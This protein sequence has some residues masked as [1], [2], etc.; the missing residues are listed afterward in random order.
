MTSVPLSAVRSVIFTV[1]PAEAGR[2][3]TGVAVDTVGAVGSVFAWVALALVD[4]L[5]A[6][7]APKARHAGAQ[8][9]VHFVLAEASVTTGVCGR[10]SE[11]LRICFSRAS[12]SYINPAEDTKGGTSENIL[13]LQSSM[14][15]SQLRPVKPG[16]QPQW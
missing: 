12:G 16:L 4:V 14:L 6:L 11:A 8:E 3:S 7:G 1:D 9:A 13:G 5:F 15:V 10:R 2:A